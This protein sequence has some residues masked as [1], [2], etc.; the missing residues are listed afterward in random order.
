MAIPQ[1]RPRSTADD[2]NSVK[3]QKDQVKVSDPPVTAKKM[4]HHTAPAT[5]RAAAPSAAPTTSANSRSFKSDSAASMPPSNSTLGKGKMP[6]SSSLLASVRTTPSKKTPPSAS[7][8]TTDLSPERRPS[9]ENGK[10]LQ[11][12]P[13]VMTATVKTPWYYALLFGIAALLAVTNVATLGLWM[14]SNAEYELKIGNLEHQIDV[15][16]ENEFYKVKD[17]RHAAILECDNKVNELEQIHAQVLV[18]MKEGHF[19]KLRIMEERLFDT[20]SILE[21]EIVED[22]VD[23]SPAEEQECKDFRP[24]CKK[25]AALGKCEIGSPYLKQTCRKSCNLC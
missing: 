8:E 12:K 23:I 19:E 16:T 21:E 6:P 7:R 5:K 14:Q 20:E 9:A 15:A 1:K 24:K 3:K 10:L 11:K 18:E 4:T 17:T 25:W 22:Q 13:V 2:A